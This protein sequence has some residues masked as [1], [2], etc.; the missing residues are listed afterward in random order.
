MK[1]PNWRTVLNATIG[2]AAVAGRRGPLDDKGQPAV[3]ADE[4]LLDFVAEDAQAA[5]RGASPRPWTILVVDDDPTVH[6]TTA[7]ALAGVQIA[8]RPLELLH[9]F[10]GAEGRTSL[11]AN[12]AVE[13]VLLDVVMETQDAGLRLARLIRDE[14]ARHDL[15]IVLRTGQP[16][17]APEGEVRRHCAIDGYATKDSLTRGVLIS[18]ITDALLGPPRGVLGA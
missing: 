9:A 18:A 11:I 4:D 14:L 15:R 6:A 12:D 16:G 3:G 8:D 17:Y 13:L 7:L 5:P 2:T 1:L 10:S